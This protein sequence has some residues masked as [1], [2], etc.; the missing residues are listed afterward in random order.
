[1]STE[2]SLTVI[3]EGAKSFAAAMWRLRL[4]EHTRQ[5]L[6]LVL[7]LL[8]LTQLGPAAFGGDDVTSQITGMPAGT[9][10]EVRLRNKERLQGTRG[11][12]SD[13]GFTLLNPGTGDRKVVFNE[14]ISVKQLTAKSHTTRNVL[15]GVGIG[16]VAAV[17][18]LAAVV[19]HGLNEKGHP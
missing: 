11:E 10:I 14:V 16:F 18:V 13:S 17:A 1:M 8:M 2:A 9:K 12:V 19:F 6:S 3:Q 4:G 5:T 7:V 15:I